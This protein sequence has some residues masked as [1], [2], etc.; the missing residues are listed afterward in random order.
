MLFIATA[1]QSLW[2]CWILSPV[3]HHMSEVV[4]PQWS[5]TCQRLSVPSGPP[6]VRGCLSPV[7]HHMSEVVCPQWS[8]TC[9]RLSVPSGP[10][11]VRGCL[12]PVVHHMSEVVCPQWSTT[13]QRLS[14]PSGPPH[15]RGCLSPVGQWDSGA[16]R[17]W[18]LC[19]S[20]IMSTRM[21]VVPRID[22]R[23][24]YCARLP[25]SL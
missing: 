7:V 12:S 10:P 3:V 19:Y 1:F 11:H 24:R 9:Q 17:L 21:V 5:T 15:V 23:G 14:V 25:L 4:C 6:H 13:C 8:T 16:P 2:V 18:E 22:N 20:F